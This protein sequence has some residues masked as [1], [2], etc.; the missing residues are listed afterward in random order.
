MDFIE[1]IEKKLG[2]KAKKNMLPLQAGDVPSTY[3]DVSDLIE[4]LNYKPATPIQEG[5]DKFIDWYL[6][7]FKVNL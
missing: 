2:K 5:I 1:A 4:D 7:F 3:A 6:E